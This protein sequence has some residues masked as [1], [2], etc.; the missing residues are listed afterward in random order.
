MNMVTRSR[1]SKLHG[2]ENSLRQEYNSNGRLSTSRIRSLPIGR[3]L[4]SDDDKKKKKHVSLSLSLTN[5]VEPD[6]AS[7]RT[8]HPPSLTNPREKNYAIRNTVE[9][10]HAKP[11]FSLQPS[12]LRASAC[13]PEADNGRLHLFR[14]ES[15]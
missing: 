15:G 7:N 4:P 2:N 10:Y 5:E 11:H 14:R 6:N 13:C 8:L 9:K 12:L 3:V 1:L